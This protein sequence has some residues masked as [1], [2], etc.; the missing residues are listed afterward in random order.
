MS[1]QILGTDLVEQILN[2]RHLAYDVKKEVVFCICNLASH[3][4]DYA[5]EL[6]KRGALKNLVPFLA[7]S[8][9]EVIH[10]ALL[11]SE[12]MLRSCGDEVRMDTNFF[13][14]QTDFWC[15]FHL[16]LTFVYTRT[17]I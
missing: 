11:F 17:F 9:T 6:L 10:V 4:S 2:L 14:L 8:D 13:R 12:T 3:G 16:C 5:G 7:V 15:Y 1:L